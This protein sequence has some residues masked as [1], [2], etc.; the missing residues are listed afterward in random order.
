MKVHFDVTKATVDAAMEALTI[1]EKA[2]LFEADYTA[3]SA[4]TFM[5]RFICDAALVHP[6]PAAA[7]RQAEFNEALDA[8]MAKV[9]D[10]LV[11]P[12]LRQRFITTAR[13]DGPAPARL[14]VL[15]AASDWG[16]PPWTV[17]GQEA[18]D[19]TRLRWLWTWREAFRQGAIAW[20]NK[21]R[22]V[23]IG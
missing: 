5:A 15:L 21:R 10:I 2:L 9:L 19:K 4:R 23:G 16:V 1:G 12:R 11:P 18:T 22:G 14:L 7:K 3:V 20:G 6:S 8:L 13:H 17:T